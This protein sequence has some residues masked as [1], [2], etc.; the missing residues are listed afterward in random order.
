MAD[1][2]TAMT[3]APM[4]PDLDPE[5]VDIDVETSSETDA[6]ESSRLA[7]IKDC[8]DQD[9]KVKEAAKAK[10][11]AKEAARMESLEKLQRGSTTAA[12]V[13]FS[14]EMITAPSC[15]AVPW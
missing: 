12:A 5:D 15:R 2:P 3:F 6:S 9:G 14:P 11:E 13:I 8:E 10:G 7:D 4:D 1:L